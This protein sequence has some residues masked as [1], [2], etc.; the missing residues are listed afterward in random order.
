[1]SSNL[2]IEIFFE[3]W[4]YVEAYKNDYK[5]NSQLAY[6]KINLTNR[7]MMKNKNALLMRNGKI[8]ELDI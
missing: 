5:T 7:F 8:S 6:V 2:E 1:M 3:L 4:L